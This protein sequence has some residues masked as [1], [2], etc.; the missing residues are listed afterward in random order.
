MFP[1]SNLWTLSMLPFSIQKIPHVSPCSVMIF[2]LS[3]K[4]PWRKIMFNPQVFLMKST[5]FFPHGGVESFL[6]FLNLPESKVYGEWSSVNIIFP[7]T[8]MAILWLL[9][10]HLKIAGEPPPKRRETNSS[11]PSLGS[12]AATSHC[13]S[14]AENLGQKKPGKSGENSPCHGDF[15]WFNGDFAWF[16]RDSYANVGENW[17]FD[18][19]KLGWCL[20]KL[21]N[22]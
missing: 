17:Y 19:P 4:G 10:V 5:I 6:A 18:Y 20:K 14:A 22:M 7:M 1:P 9:T 13:L 12:S 3:Q 21:V 15:I 8:S 16:H 11:A 2:P